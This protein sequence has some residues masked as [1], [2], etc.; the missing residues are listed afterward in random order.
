MKFLLVALILLSVIG[1]L[2]G[3]SFNFSGVRVLET[4]YFNLTQVE[5][6]HSVLVAVIDFDFN[7]NHVA[8]DGRLFVNTSEIEGNGID[9]DDNGYVDDVSGWNFVDDTATPHNDGT[10]GTATGT[11]IVGNYDSELN[12][13]GLMRDAKVLPLLVGILP[14]QR[15]AIDDAVRYAVAMGADVIN[16]SMA[17]KNW[18]IFPAD[19]VHLNALESALQDAEDA[20]VIVVTAAG[21][22]SD[23]LDETDVYPANFDSVLVAAGHDKDLNPYSDSGYGS[24]VGFALYSKDVWS[25]PEALSNSGFEERTGNS[26]ATALLS[27]VI[28]RLKSVDPTSTRDEAETLLASHAV[29]LD[30][31]TLEHGRLD[32]VSLADDYLDVEIKY[33]DTTDNDDTPI[34]LEFHVFKEEGSDELIRIIAKYL[35]REGVRYSLFQEIEHDV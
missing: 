17:L 32:V 6:A 34:T 18:T 24:D 33:V 25:T 4:D 21:N 35:Y 3:E 10:H 11:L 29:S 27:G 15:S 9:D 12:I 19:S 30:G 5:G 22:S 16:M 20:G 8:Y 31:L 2:S 1:P 7:L 26:L 13:G 28:A 23:N 14:G